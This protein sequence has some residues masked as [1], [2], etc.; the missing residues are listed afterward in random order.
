MKEKRTFFRGKQGFWFIPTQTKTNKNKPKT[1]LKGLTPKANQKQTTNHLRSLTLKPFQ[2]KQKQ[3]QK[4]KQNPTTK[5]KQTKTNQKQNK[6]NKEGL[7]PSEVGPPH[8]TL[9]P[10]KKNPN[11]KQTKKHNT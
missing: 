7:G 11:Q 2:I 1:N 4:N 3:K 8:L 9:K 5:T 6:T 10:S